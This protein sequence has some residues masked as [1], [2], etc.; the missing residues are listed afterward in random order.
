MGLGLERKTMTACLAGQGL[1]GARHLLCPWPRAEEPRS[2]LW[3][4]TA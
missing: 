3:H 1:G 2:P 4:W